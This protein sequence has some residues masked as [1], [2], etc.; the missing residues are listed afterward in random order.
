MCSPEKPIIVEGEKT[1]NIK[2]EI[3]KRIN[4]KEKSSFIES[5]VIEDENI[6][7]KL[8]QQTSGQEMPSNET[9]FQET[10]QQGPTIEEVD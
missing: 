7:K 1:Q 5:L 8:Y 6:I 3:L 2:N 4:L 9:S 10:S